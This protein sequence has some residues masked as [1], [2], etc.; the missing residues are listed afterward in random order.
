MVS[1]EI[2]IKWGDGVFSDF[3]AGFGHNEEDGEGG[4]KVVGIQ[5]R[6]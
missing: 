3:N 1:V 4:M 2:N 5:I 6:F